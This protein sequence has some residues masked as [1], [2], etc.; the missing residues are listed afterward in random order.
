VKTKK[1][2]V[3]GVIPARKGSKGVPN[4]NF[5]KVYKNKRLID[6]TLIAAKKSKR[7]SKIAITT[8]DTRIIKHSKKYKLDYVIKRQKKYST[9]YIKSIDVV[10]DVLKKIKNFKPDL[11]I[12]LQPTSPL[13]KSQ[14][15][16]ESIELL[17]RKYKKYNSLVSVSILEEPHPFKVKKITNNYLVPFI[18]NKS[19]EIPRQKL[20]K[21]YKLNGSIYLIKKKVLNNKKTFFNKTMPYIMDEKFSLN[22]D[23]LNDLKDLKKM[24]K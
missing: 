11:I 7:I 9:D 18:K 17:I 21:V 4:K 13:R 15:I 12:L 22:I 2:K 20:T 24:K 19:S 10:F 16:D 3:L 1:L 5:I 6:Y 8:D 14:H 23:T